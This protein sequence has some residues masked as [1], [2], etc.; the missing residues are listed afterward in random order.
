MQEMNLLVLREAAFSQYF[1]ISH[2]RKPNFGRMQEMNSLALRE[3]L[4]IV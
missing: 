3:A 4:Y 1:N 2:Q